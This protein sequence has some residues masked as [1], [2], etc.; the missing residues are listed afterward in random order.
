[1]SPLDDEMDGVVLKSKCSNLQNWKKKKKK[2]KKKKTR[3]RKRRF[4]FF[5]KRQ[6]DSVELFRHWA[7]G[8]VA[9]HEQFK[10]VFH[11]HMANLSLSLK[12]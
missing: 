3:Y 12:T 1:M 8:Y 7:V 2:K 11:T 5:G 9:Q 6:Y 4:N 10:S